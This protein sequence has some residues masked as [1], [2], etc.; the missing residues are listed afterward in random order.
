MRV[1]LWVVFY[2]AMAKAAVAEPVR[3]VFD[4]AASTIQFT[5]DLEGSA[6]SGTVPVSSADVVLDFD[7]LNQSRLAFTFDM[8]SARAGVVFATEAMRGENVLAVA[9]HPTAQFV[10]TFVTR[11][12]QGARLDGNLTIRGVT[13]PVSL[14]VRLFQA[15][16]L[17]AGDVSA[18]DLVVTGQIDRRDFGA[19]GF[20]NLVAPT[21]D[22]RIAA[23]I[24][25]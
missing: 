21:V 20:S 6:L 23:S 7:A 17:E 16:G 19:V 3:Y 4:R 10:S 14:N 5:F 15:Q 12:S 25:Q 9:Q 11:L 24:A 1:V 18:L 13:R 8:R 2:L 22:I